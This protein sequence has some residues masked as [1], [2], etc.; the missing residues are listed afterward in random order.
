MNRLNAGDIVRRHGGDTL[1]YFALRD[2]KEHWFW[3][4]T[5]I[6]YAVHNGVCLVSPDPIGPEA[7]QRILRGRPNGRGSEPLESGLHAD[8]CRDHHLVARAA[9]RH[10]AADDRLRLTAGMARHPR[11]IG[12][13][14]VDEVAAGRQVSV[15]NVE[16]LPLVRGPVKDVAAEAER[17]DVEVGV[18]NSSHGS[19][20]VQ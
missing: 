5:L 1:S 16:R 13:R 10:P 15:E 19:S 17:E 6:A 9:S 8:L 7:P 18:R 12:V 4:E 11:G 3:N 2:D 20:R 14:G